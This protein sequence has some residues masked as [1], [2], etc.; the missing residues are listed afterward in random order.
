MRLIAMTPAKAVKP[1]LTICAFH[2]HDLNR[3]EGIA[4]LPESRGHTY[5]QEVKS[6]LRL[7][8][9]LRTRMSFINCSTLSSSSTGGMG[10]LMYRIGTGR[11][12]LISSR[13]SGAQPMIDQARQTINDMLIVFCKGGKILSD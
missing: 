7:D 8:R 11:R 2:L 6:S 1:C 9:E 3:R 10:L 5:E 4:V 13:C 12:F